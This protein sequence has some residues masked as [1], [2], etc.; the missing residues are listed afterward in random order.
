MATISSFHIAFS[1][2]LSQKATSACIT[3]PFLAHLHRS[4]FFKR[5]CLHRSAFFWLAFFG[6]KSAWGVK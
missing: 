2:R 6:K 4:V 3:Q 1:S 5:Q